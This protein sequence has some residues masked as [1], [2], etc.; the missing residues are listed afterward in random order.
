LPWSFSSS[1]DVQYKVPQIRLHV[2]FVR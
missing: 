2:F 1:C